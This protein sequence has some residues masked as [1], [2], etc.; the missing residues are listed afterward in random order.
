M[1]LAV[2]NEPLPALITTISAL[3]ANPVYFELKAAPFP[4]AIPVT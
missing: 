2:S 4:A 1:I 3:G